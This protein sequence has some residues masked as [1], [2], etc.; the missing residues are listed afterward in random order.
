ME[1]KGGVWRRGGELDAGGRFRL[2]KARQQHEQPKKN[3]RG[4]EGGVNKKLGGEGRF[5]KDRKNRFRNDG[6]IRRKRETKD[7][8]DKKGEPWK[9]R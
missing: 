6:S 3:E 9:E 7:P 4:V 8:F 1:K 5:C 2:R